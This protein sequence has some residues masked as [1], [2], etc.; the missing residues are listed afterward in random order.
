[1]ILVSYFS[2]LIALIL[3]GIGSVALL[4]GLL[5][6]ANPIPGVVFIAAGY[7]FWKIR[8]IR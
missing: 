5:V 6:A 1:M 8:A 3:F 7:L 2:A 4:A